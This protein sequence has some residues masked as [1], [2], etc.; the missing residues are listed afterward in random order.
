MHDERQV[1]VRINGVEHQVAPG[2]SVAAALINAGQVACR[3]S[4]VGE[5]RGALCG[6]GVCFECRVRID[7][8]AQQKGCE[9]LCRDGMEIETDEAD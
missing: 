6:M 3:T 5:P 9:A 8:R 4:V 7:G 2:T 1:T